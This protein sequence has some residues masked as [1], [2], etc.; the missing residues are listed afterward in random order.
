MAK[1]KN[2]SKLLDSRKLQY[3]NDETHAKATVLPGPDSFRKKWYAI[4]TTQGYTLWSRGLSTKK[5]AVSLL[6]DEL[7]KRPLPVLYCTDCGEEIK[8][9]VEN[10]RNGESVKYHADCQHCGNEEPSRRV[11]VGA[12]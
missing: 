1:I 4:I 12:V 10:E 3:E 11:P 9:V 7:R 6:R 5:K 2:W 8:H